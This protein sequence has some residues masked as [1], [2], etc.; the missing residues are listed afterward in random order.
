MAKH[1]S[2]TRD[3]GRCASVA[4]VPVVFT[5][6]SQLWLW[7]LIA[8]ALPGPLALAAAAPGEWTACLDTQFQCRNGRCVTLTWRCDGD[9]DCPDN[10]DE[11][12]CPKHTCSERDFVC[13]NGDCI[14]LRWLCD[15]DVDCVDRSDESQEHCSHRT[16]LTTDFSCG[17]IV[18]Q[19]IP[20]AWR[21]DHE[22]DCKNGADELDCGNVT[23]LPDEFTCANHKCLAG[24]LR[25]DRD[26]DCGDGSD[27]LGCPQLTCGPHEF[28]CADLQQCMPRRW[29]CDKDPDC[30]DGSDEWAQL[31]DKVSGNPESMATPD[32][33]ANGYRCGSGECVHGSWKCDGAEDC[34]DG[35]DEHGCQYQASMGTC[36][37]G[38]FPCVNGSVCVPAF[39]LC[40][41]RLDCPD[42][43]D[44]ARCPP[45]ATDSCEPGQFQCG[46]KDCIA[47]SNVCDGVAHCRDG[48]D[49][50]SEKCGV[51]ECL[52]KNGGC[53]SICRDLLIGYECACQPGFKLMPSGNCIAEDCEPDQFVCGSKECIDPAKVCDG[54]S[55]CR[56]GSDEP[57]SQCGVNECLH[58]N[59]GCASICQDL[60]ISYECQCLPG[61]QLVD[62]KVCVD[63][64]EC[65]RVGTCSQVCVNLKGGFK[66][67]CLNGYLLDPKTGVCKALGKEPYVIFTNRHDIRKLDTARNEYSQVVPRTRN[68]VALSVHVSNN[69]I[70]WSDQH[71]KLILSAVIGKASDSKNHAV[72]IEQGLSFVEGLAVDWIHNTLYWSDSGFK[73]LSVAT[74]DGR[75]RK[76]F[77]SGLQEP[78]AIVVD[79]IAG[80][81]YWSDWGEPAK[82]EKAGM[83]GANRHAIVTHDI[84][85]PNGIAL[86][87]ANRRLY[88]V[89]SKLHTLSSVDMSGQDRVTVLASYSDLLHPFSIAVFEDKVYWTDGEEEA[90][91]S[92]NKFTGSGRRVLAENLHSPQDIVVV[93][94]LAQPSGPN[95]CEGSG[96]EYLCLP[97][98]KVDAALPLFSC[99]CAD[100][101]HLNPDG[102][103]CSAAV[104]V[105]STAARPT[106]NAENAPIPGAAVGP[107][108]TAAMPTM[109]TTAPIIPTLPTGNRG[110]LE[111]WLSTEAPSIATNAESEGGS[112]STVVGVLIPLAILAMV[113]VAGFYLWRNWKLRNTKSM[114]FD[115]PVYRKTTEDDDF[116]LDHNASLGPSVGHVYP[117]LMAV[118][119]E[120]DE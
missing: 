73:T 108:S 43:S 47:A 67:E 3:T 88:W 56:D 58:D 118:S 12:N 27:E 66:C 30:Q 82:I 60:K 42:G 98:P 77:D 95:R 4:G 75:R 94:P 71:Q 17:G 112:A 21:C 20:Q 55:H 117:P 109:E 9:L 97:A 101:S 92:M 96:C 105:V 19:C 78:R 62:G 41:E 115:N 68:A 63:V 2:S 64:D 72:V 90:I 7:L 32:C 81:L 107:G 85:W 119:T 22:T 40:D 99:A 45:N 18:A 120:D 106:I 113:C 16:C 70:L 102:K 89:D 83:N 24:R 34:K 104:G 100:N 26:D 35:S 37:P 49:E 87:L 48:S 23:C 44:E 93:H 8:V 61:F 51:N 6:S 52:V 1:A 74:M 91:F 25:C 86:D 36:R 5:A 50:H 11:E 114:N 65:Q 14:P 46:T 15:G 29:V 69:T 84:Q 54:T 59:G 79:P 53:T 57:S 13:G 33:E 103:T 10:S 39:N 76:L 80:W 110:W 111:A 31:C 38:E 28:A 116:A